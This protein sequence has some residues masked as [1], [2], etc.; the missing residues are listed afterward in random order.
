MDT[1]EA[2]RVRHSVRQYSDRPIPEDVR[3][4]LERIIAERNR[5]DGISHV[6]IFYGDPACFDSFIAHYGKFD[7]VQNYIA[8]VANKQEGAMERLGY[9]G[10]ELVL[11][12]QKMGLNTCW[13]AGTFN[14]KA[15]KAK[16][17]P[18]Q[19]LYAVIAIGYG[20][21]RG[22]ASKSKDF[23]AVSKTSRQEAADWY[24]RGVEAALLAPTAMNQQKF[25]FEQ[26]GET[27]RL[28]TKFG[29]YTKLDKGIV[30]YHFEAASG[31]EVTLV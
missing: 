23:D 1:I 9:I 30:R 28:S 6:Q 31:H 19:K 15:C 26:T 7:G 3:A 16:L 8:M 22:K 12:A 2:I 4:E 25:V 10:E 17:G 24:V 29:F 21:T 20:M 27:A 13:V 14:R 18:N 11:T 5:E